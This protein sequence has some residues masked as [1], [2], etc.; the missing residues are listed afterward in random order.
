[1]RQV[2]LPFLLHKMKMTTSAA[3]EA[4]ADGEGRAGSSVGFSC[5]VGIVAGA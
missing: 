4:R 3:G 5:G 1:M 2:S